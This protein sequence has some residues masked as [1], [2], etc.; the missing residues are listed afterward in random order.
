MVRPAIGCEVLEL[1]ARI[2]VMGKLRLSGEF[3]GAETPGPCP[4]M[5]VP[6]GIPANQGQ[7]RAE[8]VSE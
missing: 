6:L 1:R 4:E 3:F 7:A 2:F 8:T 5:W